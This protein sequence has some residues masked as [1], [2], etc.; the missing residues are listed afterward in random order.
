MNILSNNSLSN[1][2]YV[3]IVALNNFKEESGPVLAV[4]RED[5]QQIAILIEINQDV[6]LLQYVHVLLD[7]GAAVRKLLLKD[8]IVGRRNGQKLCSTSL[9]VAHSLNDVVSVESNM[10]DT[11]SAVVFYVLLNL[12]LFLAVGRLVNGH[13][14]RLLEV[15]HHNGPQRRV[16]RMDL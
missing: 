2:S 13:L 7:L 12:G 16:L 9:Q 1:K 3:V 10:L 8:L 6:Q 4:L 15:G 11:S 5:L 14:H